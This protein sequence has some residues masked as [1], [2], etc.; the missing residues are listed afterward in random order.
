MHR[1]D[2]GALQ[3]YRFGVKELFL[4]CNHGPVGAGEAYGKN[5]CFA[6]ASYVHSQ[7]AA[8]LT[9]ANIMSSCAAPVALTSTRSV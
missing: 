8:A 6:P 5:L 2:T 9:P 3:Y 1:G 4:Q 7:L